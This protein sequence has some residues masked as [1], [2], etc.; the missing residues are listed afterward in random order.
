MRALRRLRQFNIAMAVTHAEGL[1]IFSEAYSDQRPLPDLAAGDHL[2]RFH[3]P[4]RF[5]KLESYFLTV[6]VNENGKSC[7]AV[8]GLL[9]PEIVDENPHLQMESQRWGVM[10]LPVTWDPVQEAG[11]PEP[12]AKNRL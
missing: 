5:F 11:L 9:M 10:R 1:R 12:S 8:D 3:I 7:D 2:F 6:A 4:L